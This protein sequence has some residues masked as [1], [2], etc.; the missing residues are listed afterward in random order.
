MAVRGL[1]D[2][3]SSVSFALEIMREVLWVTFSDE[4]CTELGRS[5]EW[6]NYMTTCLVVS[7]SLNPFIVH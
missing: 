5:V 3:A 4:L 6:G 1:A 7:S 2:L